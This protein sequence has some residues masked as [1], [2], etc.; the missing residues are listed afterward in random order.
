MMEFHGGYILDGT[1]GS[2]ARFV[3]HSCSPNC[4]IKKT[5]V[6]GK[7]RMALFAERAILPGEELTY[8]YNFEPFN[9]ESKQTCN[10]GSQNCRGFLVPKPKETKEARDPKDALQPITN[11]KR[12]LGD[13]I[14]AITDMV[15]P[16]NKRR[17][18]IP[19]S[20]KGKPANASAGV[21]TEKGSAKAKPVEKEYVLPKGWAYRPGP[22]PEKKVF[23]EDPEE[24]MK[25]LKRAKKEAQSKKTA[26][27]DRDG[28]IEMEDASSPA[29]Q[30][31]NDTITAKAAATTKRIA[32]TVKKTA[33]TVTGTLKN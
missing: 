30:T 17:K 15:M 2:I 23:E 31:S 29:R 9:E 33:K 22:K 8:D 26:Q 11:R 3:N 5:T 12:K 6:H 25:A 32:N 14:A 1:R 7:N 16:N 27:A 21:S 20:V 18:N 24:I 4:G 28:D 13:T 10:C 19:K